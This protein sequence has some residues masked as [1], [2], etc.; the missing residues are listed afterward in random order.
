MEIRCR[1]FWQWPS[2]R[3]GVGACGP[4]QNAKR[5]ESTRST[6]ARAVFHGLCKCRNVLRVRIWIIGPSRFRVEEV[7]LKSG[8]TG[9]NIFS[10]SKDSCFCAARVVTC[11]YE[12]MEVIPS[13]FVFWDELTDEHIDIQI[14]TKSYVCPVH[15]DINFKYQ[16]HTLRW[17]RIWLSSHWGAASTLSTMTRRKCQQYDV[18]IFLPLK[19]AVFMSLHLSV[20]HSN[21]MLI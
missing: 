12:G 18:S 5:F 15:L 9:C 1:N 4:F 11:Y 21:K 16:G 19:Y 17:S 7:Y 2:A 20:C 14:H 6:F 8:P 13:D 10:N 3:R